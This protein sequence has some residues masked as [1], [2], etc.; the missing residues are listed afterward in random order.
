MQALIKHL[1]NKIFEDIKIDIVVAIT[2]NPRANGIK[3]AR[4]SEIETIVLDHQRYTSRES[5]DEELVKIIDS[6]DIDLCVLAGFMRILTPIFTDKIK[7]I[8]IHPSLLP[9]FKGTNA[10]RRSFESDM[11]VGGVTTHMVT[12]ELDGGKI[13]D[14]KCFSKEGLSFEDFKD[15]ITQTE[16]SIYHQSIKK[17]LL[18]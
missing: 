4:K 9:L 8:N 16:H 13:I 12:S 14:Q 2:N 11:K 17:V 1:H 15:K 10:I 5:F 6:R 18:T 7:A 3:K